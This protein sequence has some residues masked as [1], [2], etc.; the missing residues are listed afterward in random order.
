MEFCMTWTGHQLLQ[1]SKVITSGN[2]RWK[3]KDHSKNNDIYK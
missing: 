2:V 1:P 3:C